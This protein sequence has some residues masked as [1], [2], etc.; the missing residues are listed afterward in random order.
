MSA[1]D[2]LK[3]TQVPSMAEAAKGRLV[4][5]VRE[6]EAPM[7]SEVQNQLSL[8]KLSILEYVRGRELSQT[9][10]TRL[11]RAVMKVDILLSDN[12]LHVRTSS[13]SSTGRPVP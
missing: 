1:K 13:A 12:S 11:S 5:T 3:G 7:L 8:T 4:D 2:V 6:A 10:L 9:Q